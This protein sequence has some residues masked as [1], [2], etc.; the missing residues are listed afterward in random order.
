MTQID[1]VFF[2]V[3][4]TLR[5]DYLQGIMGYLRGK[6]FKNSNV[7][8]QTPWTIPSHASMFT[9]L[10]PSLHGARETYE[11]K[12]LPLKRRDFLLTRILKR[13]GFKNYLL[14]A[15]PLISPDLGFTY[16]DHVYEVEFLKRIFLSPRLERI[17]LDKLVLLREK[18][19]C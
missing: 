19:P 10:Y 2:I 8:A 3:I 1:H 4:D 14:F 6:G 12:V 7:V 11:G 17:G 9:G 15:N 13:L 18:I 5:L 16:F